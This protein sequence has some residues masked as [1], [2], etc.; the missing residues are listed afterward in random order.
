M[1]FDH[2]WRDVLDGGTLLIARAC[3]ILGLFPRYNGFHGLHRP[4]TVFIRALTRIRHH[5][6]EGR[7]DGLYLCIRPQNS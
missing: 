7:E 3:S 1:L 4:V 5:G 2:V 6:Y